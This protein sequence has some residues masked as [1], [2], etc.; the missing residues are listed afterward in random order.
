M[1]NDDYNKINR[2]LVATASGSGMDTAGD[3][4]DADTELVVNGRIP[5]SYFSTQELLFATGAL[6]NAT[7]NNGGGCSSSDQKKNVHY[8]S[9]VTTKKCPRTCRIPDGYST[10]NSNNNRALEQYMQQ[11]NTP[12]VG[13][14]TPQQ[15]QQQQQQQPPAGACSTFAHDMIQMSAAERNTIQEEIHGVHQVKE[16]DPDHIDF[17]IRQI[18][19][20]IKSIK[21]ISKEAYQK[22]CF[23]APTRYQATTARN[24]TARNF[25][26][27]FLRST[28]FDTY[29]ASIKILNHFNE[30]A[31]LWG[32]DKVAQTITIDDLNDDD[33]YAL[34]GGA[35]QLLPSK[36]TAGRTIFFMSSHYANPRTWK[37]YVSWCFQRIQFLAFSLACRPPP[38]TR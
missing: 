20:E 8:P 31:K 29:K 16:E 24:S 4:N 7:V 19:K 13:A 30:K 17:C 27:M 21:D 26:L 3:E 34:R 11:E 37:S 32:M 9:T 38:Y 12:A 33:M 28:N 18:Q 10:M 14:I 15:Q 5:P 1:M 23:L 22:A 2:R 6:D 36:D 25:Y 35:T